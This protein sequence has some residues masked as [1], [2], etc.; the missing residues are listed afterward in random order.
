VDV[1][2]ILAGQILERGAYVR[3]VLHANPSIEAARQGWRA[4]LAR[5]RQAGA[6]DDPMVEVSMAPLSIGSSSARFGYEVAIQQQLPWFGKR[7]LERD[8]MTAEA[9]AS[10]SD[11]ETTR[12]ELAMTALLLYDQYYVALRSLEINAQHL[13]LMQSLRAAATAQF[14]TGR[15]SAQDALQAEAELTHLEHDAAVLATD[16]DVVVAQMNELLHREPTAPL[17]VPVAELAPRGSPDVQ[18]AKQLEQ[19]AVG[20]R[21][22]IAAARLHAHAE[23]M[24]ADAAGRDYYPT[25]TVSSS[26]SSM[27]DM[28]EHRWMVG[29]GV[30][31]PLPTERRAA[32]VDEAHAA[33]AQYE[34]E[35][36]RMS[37]MARTQV[38]IALRKLDESEHVLG[39]FRRRLLPVAHEQVDAAQAGFITSQTPFMSVVQ[40]EKNLRSVELDH[41]LAQAE[42]DRRHAE[43]DRA[44]GRIP[45]LDVEE[46]SR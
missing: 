25:V 43:L 5:V 12:R 39:L 46:S 41:E 10:A 1:G 27:W 30:N 32:V 36:E 40:A 18:N 16:R 7:A 31:V 19:E 15:G 44:L 14:E 2:K 26:Y 8:A 34:S 37:D 11:L 35:V 42:C 4:A 29:V 20:R 38:Y 9:D 17:P 45:G 24:K 3:A 22:E 28:P 13:Q 6:F 23:E 33:R 21:A